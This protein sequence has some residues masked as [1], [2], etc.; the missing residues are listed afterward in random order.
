MSAETNPYPPDAGQEPDVE[1]APASTPEKKSSGFRLFFVPRQGFFVTPI[2]IY[3]NLLVFILMAATGAGIFMPHSE[4]LV[5]WGA[6]FRPATLSGQ[7]WRLLTNCFEH[8]GIFHLAMN[9]YALVNIGLLLEP[10]LG[11]ARFLSAYLLTGLCASMV[12]LWW[13]DNVISAGASGAIFGMYGLY[14]SLLTSGLTGKETRKEQ[15]SSILVF[16]LYNL[17]YGL[18]GGIDNAAHIGGLLSGVAIGYAMIG[19]LRYPDDRPLYY[20]NLVLVA[21]VTLVAIGIG[22]QNLANDYQLYE[23]RMKRFVTLESMAMD[24]YR[25]SPDNSKENLLY[26]IQERGLYFWNE[27]IKMI[28]SCDHLLLSSSTKDRNRQLKEYCQL[29]VNSYELMSK[30]IQEESNRYD[31]EITA[32]NKQIEEKIKALGGD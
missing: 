9:L 2:L 8:I 3:L 22:Y 32:I 24:I 10:L 21:C 15:L 30:A 13:H 25:M 7:W 29:R 20:R 23:A 16:V 18:K 4:S 19:S 12:S 17:L 6:N 1:D 5:K 31:A 11:K 28:D 26:E 14:L 27:N